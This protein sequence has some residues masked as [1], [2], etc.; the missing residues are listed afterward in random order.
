MK[1]K[2]TFHRLLG[3]MWRY[4][5]VSSMALAFILLT[6]MVTTALP[7]LARYFIDQFIG[8]NQAWAGLPLMALYYGLFLL[9][10]LFTFLGKYFFARVAQSVVRD[11]RQESF[12][13]IQRLQ[14]AYFDRTP[15]GA[16]V[17]RLTNDTQAVADMFSEIFSNFL[18]SLLI[19]VVT[20]SAMF[21]LNWQLTLM[22]ALFLPLM[23]ASILLYQHLS[24]RQLKQVRDKLSDLNVKL[25]ESIEGMRI[26]QAFGQ[27]KRLLREFEEINGQHLGFT[28]RYLNINSLFLRPA[29]SLLKILAYGVIL[30]YFGL[31][32][33]VV[34]ITA[35]IMYA[36]IQYVNQLFNP[37]IDVMQNYSVLQTSMVAAERVF[38]IIDRTDYE[39][40]QANQDLQIQDGSI[41]FK[42]VSFSYDGKRD[43]LRDISFS[44]K[45]G[46]TIAFVGSTGSGKSS[47][48]NLFLRF[49]EFER[50][51]I[52]IDGRDIKDFSQEELR[53][54]IG[55]VLQD[56]FL[57]HG[58]VASNIQ[59]YQEQLTREE[60]IEAAKFVDAH[61]FISQL[62]QGYDAPVTERGA[63]FS[64]GQRQLLA[65]ARTIATKP[66]I[67]ILDEATANIDSETE[68]LIQA[69]LRKMRRGRTTIA[70]AHRLSTIQDADCIYVLD[71]GRIIESGSH[72][73]L[74]AQDGTYKKMYQLQ[75]GM[76]ES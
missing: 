53:R 8:R 64:S 30:T 63:T 58:T 49:Y 14:M 5:I 52:L 56:P 22:I 15:A 25:S 41:A 36:F 10:V 51:Q 39:P 68:E 33:Q 57:Y 9:R 43:V 67:L 4:R 13:N 11:L 28:N 34:G 42:H 72:E 75:A 35:G 44:V 1:K 62:P 24:N 31:T 65:F 17:S 32:W 20:L 54:K 16:I 76:M 47:I 7:L 74:L 27:E 46:Q 2:A 3:Y 19:L 71:K 66:K 23:A 12:A 59:L 40:E 70:I 61:G 45:K 37:L 6:T 26:I 48:I 73:E 21:A 55:L 60:I 69:S 29:M 18:S 38:E 50:G